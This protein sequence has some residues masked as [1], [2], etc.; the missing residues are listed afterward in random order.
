MLH[1]V[2]NFLAIFEKSYKQQKMK[3]LLIFAILVIGLVACH[4]YATTP[5]NNNTIDTN[6]QY[7][8][9]NYINNGVDLK[10]KFDGYSFQFGG[11]GQVIANKAGI[12]SQGEWSITADSL[13][14]KNFAAEPL[15]GLNYRYKI[16]GIGNGAIDVLYGNGVDVVSVIWKL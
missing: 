3:Q 5:L 4:P 6:G 12:V 16:N 15:S 11:S 7:V 14:I 8:I 10:T 2:K 1:I 13:I 9:Q